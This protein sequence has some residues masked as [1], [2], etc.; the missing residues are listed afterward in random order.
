MFIGAGFAFASW[1]GRA[2][3]VKSDLDLDA[4]GLGLLLVCLS[5][6]AVTAMPMT[7]PIVQ[8]FGPARSV[9]AGAVLQCSGLAGV[10]IGIWTGS[11]LLT[12]VALVVA[13]SGVSVWDVAMNVEGA[14]VEQQ[15]RRSIMSKFHAGFSL[16][17][18]AGAGVSAVAAAVG[19]PVA[20]QVLATSVLLAVVAVIGTRMFTPPEPERAERTAQSDGTLAAAWTTPRTLIVGVMVLCF[21]FAEGVAS[22]WTAVAFVDGLDSSDAVGAVGFGMFV[23]AMTLGRLAG[24][25]VLDRWGRV[26]VLRASAL[27]A[28]A[29]VLLVATGPVV[30]VAMLGSLL[31]GLG[32]ALGFP[33]GISAAAD[34]KVAALHVSVVS[35]IGYCAFLAGPPLVGVLG[36]A[37]GVRTALLVVLVALAVALLT[38]AAARPL[39]AGSA[40]SRPVG[41]TR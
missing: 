33:T 19:I 5:V 23:T 25:R 10:S 11:I 12:G 30:A 18:V 6:G 21:A 7:G 41:D 37:V 3:A 28:A 31:W 40:S 36:D 24:G 1:I 27:I 34:E 16:G 22:D 32:A 38:S 2:P 4:S 29:G 9:L 13:G 15:L 20:H 26:V 35:T 14:D 17:T 39:S 8:R